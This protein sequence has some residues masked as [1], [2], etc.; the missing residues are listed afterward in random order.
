MLRY[1][2][3][4]PNVAGRLSFGLIGTQCDFPR[5]CAVV[6]AGGLKRR[7]L[8]VQERSLSDAL[9]PNWYLRFLYE[10]ETEWVFVFEA[11]TFQAEGAASDSLLGTVYAFTARGWKAQQPATD[12]HFKASAKTAVT[13]VQ[14]S[15]AAR[16]QSDRFEAFSEKCD[17]LLS[18]GILDSGCVY[19]ATVQI[20]RSGLVTLSN[21]TAP[22]SL[23]YVASLTGRP[24]AL[25][26]EQHGLLYNQTF[27]F[28]KDISHSHKHHEHKH[29]T[30]T[31]AQQDEPRAMWAAAIQHSMHRSVLGHRRSGSSHR[32]NDAIGIMAYMASFDAFLKAER[33][34]GAFGEDIPYGVSLALGYN[35]EATEDSVKAELDNAKKREDNEKLRLTAIFG[36]PVA[37]F[38]VF[39]D[40]SNQNSI[41]WLYERLTVYL[42]EPL[43]AWSM[44]LALTLYFT[45]KYGGNDIMSFPP[46]RN[47]I[48]VFR[49]ASRPA[50]I[51]YAALY[52]S[53]PPAVIAFLHFGMHLNWRSRDV[54]LAAFWLLV[55]A[56]LFIPLIYIPLYLTIGQLVRRMFQI[57]FPPDWRSFVLRLIGQGQ[58]A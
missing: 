6:N 41:Y 30:I 8:C 50:A 28:L 11:G 40:S 25:S 35:L 17:T 58:R 3:W 34:R 48:R 52:A 29:D 38:S 24:A 44:V 14:R 51:L 13:E 53:I 47:V 15:Y 56:Q 2:G 39:K 16:G 22:A 19:R 26:E 1:K 37:L 21:L 49:S 36:I 18:S 43:A 57:A 55:L 9:I 4:I 7:I 54:L 46:L 27:Y 5:R 45:V 23:E 31:S 42:R 10:C 32:L 20:D 12:L 33:E